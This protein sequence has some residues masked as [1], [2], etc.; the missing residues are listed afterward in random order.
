MNCSAVRASNYAENELDDV[1][2]EQEL[3]RLIER[4]PRRR[5]GRSGC[6]TQTEE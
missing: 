1:V 5:P 4:H 3:K 2:P 6:L